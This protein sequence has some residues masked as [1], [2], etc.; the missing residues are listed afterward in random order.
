[1]PS[2]KK[3]FSLDLIFLFVISA[4]VFLPYAFRL[5]YYLDDWYYIYDGIVAGPNIFHAM[6]S[7]DRP[8]RGYF[9]DILF[10]VFGPHPLPYHLGAYVW[11]LFAGIGA[12]WLLN[13]IWTEHKKTNFFIALLFTLYPGY[14]WWVSGVEYQP[15]AAS[16][17]LQ[18]FSVLFTLLS[19]QTSDRILKTV[20]AVSAIISG[21]AYIALVDYAAGAEVF[22]FLCVYLLVS[23]NEQ[24]GFLKRLGAAFKAWI[25]YAGVALGYILWRVFLFKSERQATD[26]GLHI[27]R[28]NASPVDYISRMAVD[29]YLSVVNTSVN[30]WFRQLYSR[31]VEFNFHIPVLSRI[32]TLLVIASLSYLAYRWAEQGYFKEQVSGRSMPREALSIGI[33]SLFIGVLPV[34]LFGRY[35]NLNIYSHYGLPLSLVAAILLAGCICLIPS[36]RIRFFLFSVFVSIAALTH[37]LIAERTLVLKESFE[38]FWWQAAW[39]M[40]GI[41]PDTTLVTLYPYERV[42]DNPLGLP[43]AVN[44]IYFP[45]ARNENPVRYA[46]STLM[47]TNENIESILMG[48]RKTIEGYRTYEM[49]VQYENILVLAQPSPLSCVRVIDGNNFIISDKDPKSITTIFGHSNIENI[50]FVET[51]TLPKYAFGGEP[52][53]GWCYYFEKADLAVQQSD[54]EG[55]AKLGDTVLSLGLTPADQVEWFPF[56][57]AYAMIGNAESLDVLLL[58]VESNEFLSNQLCEMVRSPKASSFSSLEIKNLTEDHSCR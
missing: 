5:T 29:F 42:V 17:A 53:H 16:L 9:F 37:S 36:H 1:M 21:W 23:R 15:M 2:I 45:E 11:R 30:A 48:K 35:V 51:S 19:I 49:V 41:N 33:V 27:Q 54:W 22:R 14:A 4:V 8:I 43:E 58:Q 18:V 44:L 28:F 38:D 12:F 20:Y 47:P 24:D 7:V 10:S 39:R 52:E 50:N 31:M 25:L 56:I 55:A 32:L 3:I 26:I 40:P 13:I 6:F 34:I 57:Q 46:V